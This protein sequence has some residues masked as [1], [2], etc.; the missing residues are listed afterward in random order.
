MRPI[1]GTPPAKV[2][3]LARVQ[4]RLS[5]VYV[6]RCIIHRDQN[7]VTVTDKDGVVHVPAATIGALVLGPGT[8]VTHQAM[9]LLAD[10]GSTAVW[11]GEQGVRYYAHGRGLSRT[12]RWIES[13]A[14]IVSNRDRRLAVARE[15][16]GMR[17]PGES[18]VGATM[19]QLRGRE[20]ARV[21]R[22]YREAAELHG[23]EWGR[24]SYDN[25]DFSSGDPINQAL[26]ATTACLYGIVHAVVVSLGCSPG[27]GIVHT[28]H[29]RSFVFDVADLYKA[30][31]AIPVAFEVAASGTDDVPSEARR[32]MRDAFHE[33]QLLHR[34]VRDVQ[35]LLAEGDVSQVEDW[36]VIYL[37]D[38]S[39]GR[40][41]GGQD[42]A[43]EMEVP[44]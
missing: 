11:V 30:D 2:K 41:A 25:L 33:Q 32:A 36:D 26:S 7:A 15:M 42:Y 40:V 9:M 4:D 19:Q 31:L 13:Q 34:C 35:T 27:L 29:E 5:F 39:T 22:A 14:A 24:R 3:E 44:W 20:G 16:Y 17:F 1:P 21:R 18:V 28:G 12:S 37:W 23:V 38:G 43:D 10:S 6:E 8:R